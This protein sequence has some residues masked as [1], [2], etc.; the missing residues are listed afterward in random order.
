MKKIIIIVLVLLF[1][2]GVVVFLSG[3]VI[4]VIALLHNIRHGWIVPSP[5][6]P[7][8]N[9]L[10]LTPAQAELVVA[11]QRISGGTLSLSLRSMLDASKNDPVNAKENTLT[12]VRY[13]IPAVSSQR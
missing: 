2:L 10:E 4:Y 1:C 8:I 9:E 11:S 3:A 13:G 5:N 7:T 12:V 6:T